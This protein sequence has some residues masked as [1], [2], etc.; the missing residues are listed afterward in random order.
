MNYSIIKRMY[1][2]Q[3]AEE[4]DFISSRDVGRDE[5]NSCNDSAVR[6]SYSKSLNRIVGKL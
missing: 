3:E 6:F 2:V 4:S 5:S 1:K